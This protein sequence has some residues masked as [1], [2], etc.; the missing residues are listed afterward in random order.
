MGFRI[1]VVN[2]AISPKIIGRKS[3]FGSKLAPYRAL[4]YLQND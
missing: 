1:R 2:L 3:E 4:E